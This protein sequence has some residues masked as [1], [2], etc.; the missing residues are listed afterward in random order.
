MVGVIRMKDLS[1]VL[2]YL[3][4]MNFEP[5]MEKFEDRLI[6]QKTV[7]LLKLLGFDLGYSFSLY[8][9]GPYSPDLTKDLYEH[10]DEVD[11]LKTGYSPSEEEK[12]KLQKLFD[13]SDQLNPTMLEII[14]TYE[15]LVR[16]LGNDEK[17]A[18]VNLKKLKP[19]YSEARLSIGMSKAKEL[20]LT[21][22]KKELERIKKEFEEWEEASTTD[23]EG[24]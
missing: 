24:R 8:V 23:K 20:F 3:K 2:A 14:S 17:E 16:R 15:Y 9:R 11:H 18:I 5:N 12:K 1:R 19:F 7:C 6:I 13:I 22:D 10:T 4:E 21:L